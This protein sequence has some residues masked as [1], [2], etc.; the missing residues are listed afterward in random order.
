MRPFLWAACVTTCAMVAACGDE[1]TRK[2]DMKAS[3][4]RLSPKGLHKNPAFSQVVVA[5]GPVNTVYIGGQ[6]AVD[7]SGQIVG[8]GDIAS[9]AEQVARNLLVALSAAGAAPRHV[10]KW[11]IYV[12]QGQS[13]GPAMGAFRRVFGDQPNP[14]AVITVLFVSALAHPDF[15]L[16]IDGVAV[17]PEG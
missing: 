11:N 14:P 15:L 7:S 10:V 3:V 16:E 13:L 12:V 1:K 4:E 2:H 17:V 8:K 6:N 9:Q 5:T